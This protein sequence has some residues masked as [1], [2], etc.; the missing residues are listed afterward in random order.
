MEFIT[1]KEIAEIL[2][3]SEWFIYKHY[4]RFGGVK[5]GKA[6][7]FEKSLFEEVLNGHLSASREMAVRL[8]EGRDE[9]QGERLSNQTGGKKRRS[10]R[11]EEDRKDKYGLLK[12]MREQT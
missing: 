8:L 10:R 11:K 6:L 3:V 4:Q 9:I 5:F 12:I 2:K 7:R 1:A